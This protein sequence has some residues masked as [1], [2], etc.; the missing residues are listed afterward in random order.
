MLSQLI[1]PPL[2][3]VSV[4]NAVY[5][6]LSPAPCSSIEAQCN[7]RIIQHLQK[8]ENGLERVSLAR[9]KILSLQFHNDKNKCYCPYVGILLPYTYVLTLALYVVVNSEVIGLAPE[10]YIH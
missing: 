4:N 3:V 5:G 8:K 10:A 9:H 2:K 7:R 1:A 6:P